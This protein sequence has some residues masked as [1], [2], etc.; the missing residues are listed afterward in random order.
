M[1]FL[2]YILIFFLALF[3][4][5]CKSTNEYAYKGN[6]SENFNKPVANVEKAWMAKH[7]Y[8]QDRRLL[9][10]MI[11]G[12]RWGAVQEYKEDG[13]V[14]YRDWWIRD[15]KL[16]DLQ[17]SPSTSLRKLPT[18]KE[19]PKPFSL[20]QIVMEKEDSTKGEPEVMPEQVKEIFDEVETPVESPESPFLPPPFEDAPS[21]EPAD[22]LLEADSPFPPLPEA[23]P[24]L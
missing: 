17:P 3:H 16:E 2:L 5:G 11:G 10:P 18:Q 21:V 6:F 12:S 13:T 24:P 20:D 15:V 8:D 14:E 23:L 9:I 1:K 7:N 4:S 19:K 22:G